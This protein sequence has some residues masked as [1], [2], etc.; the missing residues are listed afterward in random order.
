MLVQ[1]GEHVVVPSA[2]GL[3]LAQD[4][5]L[6]EF[7]PFL[8][9]LDVRDDLVAAGDLV[10]QALPLGNIPVLVVIGILETHEVHQVHGRG[11]AV[12]FVRL[13]TEDDG[14]AGIEESAVES[15]VHAHEGGI[16]VG[17]VGVGRRGAQRVG[18]FQLQQVLRAGGRQQ[19]GGSG[20][21]QYG[22]NSLHIFRK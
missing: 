6:A 19:R 22:D 21:R 20:D 5:L 7:F 16:Q 14:H 17:F 4:L 9:V 10:V 2:D 3:G 8:H 12:A 15:V 18:I 11:V 1:H 13:G